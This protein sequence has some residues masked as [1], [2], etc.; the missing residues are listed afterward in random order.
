[1]KKQATKKHPP[2]HHE[3][4]WKPQQRRWAKP[5]AGEKPKS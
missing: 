4:G 3:I 2:R 1:M 5:R